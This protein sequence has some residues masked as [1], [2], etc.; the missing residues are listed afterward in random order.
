M[1]YHIV[2]SP[3]ST[4][5]SSTTFGY[6]VP[7]LYV[8]EYKVQ[9]YRLWPFPEVEKYGINYI[10]KA[11]FIFTSRITQRIQWLP[12]DIARN[13]TWPRKDLSMQVA[14]M[15]ILVKREPDTG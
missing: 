10:V 12:N 13:T 4:P 7:T 6:Y 11:C 14:A 5:Y 15:P 8:V 9:C 3:L 2:L 1:I